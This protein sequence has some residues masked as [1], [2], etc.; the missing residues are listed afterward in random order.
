MELVITILETRNVIK[1]QNV[2]N[3]LYVIT[4]CIITFRVGISAK[5]NNGVYYILRDYI[6]IY[7]IP[8]HRSVILYIYFH[9][10]YFNADERY[11]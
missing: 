11:V 2:I 6:K 3:Q 1:T 10:L 7:C 5:C 8:Y 9:Y 4:L